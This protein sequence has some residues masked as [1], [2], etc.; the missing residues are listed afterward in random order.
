MKLSELYEECL[1][2]ESRLE[3]AI[4]QRF[5]RGMRVN[6]RWGDNYVPAHVNSTHRTRV[7]VTSEHGDTYWVDATRLAEFDKL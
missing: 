7:T 1:A 3:V 5:K 2:A 4:E 6:V